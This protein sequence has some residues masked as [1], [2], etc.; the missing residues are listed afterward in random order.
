M[1]QPDVERKWFFR[2]C[3]ERSLNSVGA[4]S[5][6]ARSVMRKHCNKLFKIHRAITAY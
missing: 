4:D 3:Q 6:S 2:I 1:T 5:I